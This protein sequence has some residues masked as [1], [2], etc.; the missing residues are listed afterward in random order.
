MR[1]TLNKISCM[2]SGIDTGA[3]TVLAHYVHNGERE[4]I[5]YVIRTNKIHTFLHFTYTME[6]SPS[7]EAKQ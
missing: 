3:H 5:V 2:L 7:W 1:K 4:K 6:Q